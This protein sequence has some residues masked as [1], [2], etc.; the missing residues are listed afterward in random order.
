[1]NMR[2]MLILIGGLTLVIGARLPWIS[3]PL[4]FGVEGA[5]YG[6]I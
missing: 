3:V 5:P 6:A 4:L 2:R 1:M